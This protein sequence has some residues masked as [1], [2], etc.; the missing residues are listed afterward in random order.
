MTREQFNLL[1]KRLR[2][3]L[4]EESF[5]TGNF[6]DDIFVH[7]SR[8]LGTARADSDLDI[9]IRVGVVRFD[10]L[11]HDR[12]ARVRIGSDKAE[13]LNEALRQERLHAGEAG[14]SGVRKEIQLLVNVEMALGFEKGVQ[15]TVIKERG[16]FDRGPF[17]E[18]PG[19]R[20][21]TA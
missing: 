4:W 10:A 9:G 1:A 14:I 7:G 3:R 16:K 13:T 21:V 6:G 15:I 19:Q 5:R 12:I 20:F 17:I 8:A 18:L 11:V 2:W